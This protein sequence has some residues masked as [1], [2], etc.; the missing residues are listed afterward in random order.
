MSSSGDSSKRLLHSSSHSAGPSRKRC[1]SPV[2]SVPLSTLVIGSLAPTRAD[3]L[4][5]RKRFR[6]SY[7]S[8]ASIEEDVEVSPIETGIDMELGISDGDDVRDHVEIDPRDVRD[9]TEEY[10][11]DTSARMGGKTRLRMALLDFGGI[12]DCSEPVGGDQLLASETEAR[13]DRDIT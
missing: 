9:D 8:E 1:R 4:P 6:D 2:D 10:E 13:M 3:L 5:P 12:E 11:A 7:S